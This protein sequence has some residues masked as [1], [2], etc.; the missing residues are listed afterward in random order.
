MKTKYTAKLLIGA[1][2]ISLA[3]F[4]SQGNAHASEQTTG[5]AP[6]QPVNFDS[7]NVTP[8][9]KTFYQVLHMEGISEDQREQYL[10]QLHEDPSS[11]QNVFQNQLKMPSTR[12]VVL[13]NKM[14][15]TAYYTTMTYPKSN[16]MHTLVELKKIQ[17][18]AKK[19][20]LSL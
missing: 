8:D 14:R 9:Q 6:T 7:I 2:T 12:N 1:A 13:R 5:L 17:I 4:I 20:L 19:Y 15:F 18:K 11:A 10:K 16:V 3:T